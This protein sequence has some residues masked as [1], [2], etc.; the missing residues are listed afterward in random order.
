LSVTLTPII[1]MTIL[2]LAFVM[3]VEFLFYEIRTRAAQITGRPTSF[4]VFPSR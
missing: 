3:D 4:C 2:D 1:P